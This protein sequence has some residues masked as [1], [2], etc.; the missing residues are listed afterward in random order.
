MLTTTITVITDSSEVNMIFWIMQPSTAVTITIHIC[1]QLLLPVIT[2]AQVRTWKM[3]RLSTKIDIK[4][5]LNKYP[6]S[7][8]Q[9]LILL[10]H[11]SPSY[12]N[13]APV[14]VS[15]MSSPRRDDG[16]RYSSGREQEKTLLNRLQHGHLPS[17]LQIKWN[18]IV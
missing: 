6:F 14:S 12:R 4:S 15:S 9:N 18:Q 2:I 7:H 16:G 8:F 5:K 13:F 10:G 1:K 17:Y 3:T 11:M